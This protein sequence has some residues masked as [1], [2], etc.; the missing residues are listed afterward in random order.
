[1][2]FSTTFSL[3]LTTFS[4]LLIHV[5]HS[6]RPCCLRAVRLQH[7]AVIA[8]SD[9]SSS[10]QVVLP[11]AR[12]AR[13]DATKGQ[14]QTML[15]KWNLV[16]IEAVG[17]LT[18]VGVEAG[19]AAGVAIT[20]DE[21]VLLA[22]AQVAVQAVVHRVEDTLR[23]LV[24][25]I[26]EYKPLC[27]AFQSVTDFAENAR[28]HRIHRCCQRVVEMHAIVYREVAVIVVILISVVGTARKDCRKQRQTKR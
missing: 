11:V 16:Q 7:I 21:S 3:L 1:M 6:V 18:V 14:C 17:A 13:S 20:Y 9:V 24:G 12:G 4:S 26:L 25:V 23:R 2:R 19:W 8:F 22:Y 10:V 27:S 28:N 5:Q 15:P